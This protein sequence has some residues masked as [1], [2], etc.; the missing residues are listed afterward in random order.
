MII[1]CEKLF[2]DLNR[3]AV[4]PD[5][6]IRLIQE[7]AARIS[8]LAHAKK[9]TAIKKR[10]RDVLALRKADRPPVWCNPVGCWNELLPENSLVCKN[11]NCRNLEIFFKKL[12]IKNEIG[13]DTPINDYYMLNSAVDV[14]PSNI[15]GLDIHR[16]E[17]GEQGSAW[18]YHAVLK[19]AADFDKLV[20]P[21]Y[22]IN[23]NATDALRIEF[24]RILGNSMP[25]KVSPISGYYAGAT[26]CYPAAELRGLEQLMMDM[27]ES[28]ELVHK[29]MEIICQGEMSKLDAIIEAGN[30]IPNNDGAMFLSDPL[31]ENHSGTYDLNACWI[32]GNSQE[33]DLI[34]PE[35]FNEFLLEY[36]K[37]LFA[38]FGAVCYGCCENLT[39][40]LD[41]VLSIPNLRL[42]T[43]SGWT[44]LPELVKKTGNR[45]CIMW[46]HKASEVVCPDGMDDFKKKIFEQAEILKESHYQVVLRELQTLM[47]HHRRLEEWTQLSIAAVEKFCS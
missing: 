45:C 7:L 33:F 9:M 4:S 5:G 1:Y 35:M 27:I 26:V 46:R 11:E 22:K 40:K 15:W 13:D 36:Q 6:E 17:L 3:L 29:L 12:L 8:E 18:R 24:S 19:S 2:N 21:R 42:L 34:R 20:I 47:G 43:C 38:R 37:K 23:S 25:V 14:S 31:R 41:Y 39:H 30:I 10:W 16:E 32:H 44:D 28:P